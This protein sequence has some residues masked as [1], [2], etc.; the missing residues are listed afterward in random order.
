MSE[1][2]AERLFFALWPD[3]DARD[4]L[5]ALARS[6]L[7]P[8]TGRLVPAENIHLTLVFLGR[9]DRRLRDCAERVASRLS[10]RA[11]TL[12][13]LRIGYWPRPRVVWSAPQHTPALLTEL[14]STL[15]NALV[16]CGHEPTAKPFRAHVTLARKVRG[17][18]RETRHAP[19]RWPVN[20][21]HL[22]ISETLPEGARYWRVRSWSLSEAPMPPTASMG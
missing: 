11:F 19:V 4:A 18:L 8:G 15:S 21:F 5:A 6:R 17:P 14:A 12:E 22:V 13:F 7:A 16:E 3:D 1:A 2:P 10:V 9:V 20:A